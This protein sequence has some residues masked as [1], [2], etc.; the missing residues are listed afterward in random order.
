MNWVNQGAIFVHGIFITSLILIKFSN[1]DYS[2][3]MLLKTLTAFGILAEAGF[4]RTIER[5]VAFFFSGAS[6]LPRNRKEYDE[7][8]EVS[9]EPN[10]P[11]LAQLLYSTKFIYLI[12]SGVTIVLL[13]TIG[14]AFLWNLF[15]Q[16]GHDRGLWTGYVLMILQSL[17]LLQ[18]IKWRSF[19]T[20]LQHLS[21]Y[22]RL[23]TIISVVRIF[24]F[25]A[26]LL[27]QG[28]RKEDID[29]VCE[30]VAHHHTPGKV[31]TDNFKILYDADRLVNLKDDV[32]L[33][34]K[35]KVR[36]YIDKAFLTEAAREMAERIYL[37]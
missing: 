8:S 24:G 21:H 23:N 26:I 9:G 18:G 17:I 16:S 2:F 1:L 15:T 13:S 5:S 37:S 25:L 12:L 19:M 27:N 3:W 36:R 33:D 7:L 20:G 6:K 30:I 10:L 35:K 4:G 32:D 28:F 22:Y 14:I 11:Q 29:E 31:D 34:D